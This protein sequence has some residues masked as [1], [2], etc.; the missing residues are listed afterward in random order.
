ML[1]NF[2]LNAA[3]FAYSSALLCS[4]LSRGTLIAAWTKPAF[5]A[6]RPIAHWMQTRPK[7]LRQAGK[8]SNIRRF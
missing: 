3:Q 6:A 8:K 2:S 4:I 7:R 1:Q 5:S